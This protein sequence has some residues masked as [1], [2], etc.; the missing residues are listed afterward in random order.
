MFRLGKQYRAE[1]TVPTVAPEPPPP[2]LRT[3]NI[4]WG[5]GNE[6]LVEAHYAKRVDGEMVFT[7]VVGIDY[8]WH[9]VAEYGFWTS[10]TDV[11][12]RASGYIYVEEVINGAQDDPG[13]GED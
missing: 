8:K 6:R 13:S 5:F 12:F 7:R 3:W 2:P 4:S 1:S 9:P 10:K 11:V